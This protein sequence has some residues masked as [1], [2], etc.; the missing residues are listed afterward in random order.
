MATDQSVEVTR[1]R[2]AQGDCFV[3]VANEPIVGT[4]LF[5]S[6][7]QTKGCPWY[8]QPEVASFGQFA[9]EPTLQSAGLGRRLIT[10]VED[11]ARRSGAM[12]I[13]LDT[14]EPARHLVEWY[15]R[16]GYRFVETAQWG[17]TNYR[18]VIMS[19]RL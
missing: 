17:H 6:A 8:D 15:G 12:E 11:R 10:H 4:I 5:R 7:A 18:S 1:K 3:A 9:V 19:K 14:A 13:A 16:L 2:A